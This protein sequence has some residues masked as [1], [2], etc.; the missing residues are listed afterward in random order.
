MSDSTYPAVTD[1]PESIPGHGA[2]IPPITTE[3]FR[4]P[5]HLS[6][7]EKYEVAQQ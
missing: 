7:R 1:T 4:S 2:R 6:S 3:T 5:S